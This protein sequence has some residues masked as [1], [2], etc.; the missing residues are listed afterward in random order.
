MAIKAKINLSNSRSDLCQICFKN[1]EEYRDILSRRALWDSSKG[2]VNMCGK[3]ISYFFPVP[4]Y[5]KTLKI[6][7]SS[8]V[9]YYGDKIINQY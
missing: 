1:F 9:H 6:F 8:Y 5:P 3:W 4:K 2:G 7:I